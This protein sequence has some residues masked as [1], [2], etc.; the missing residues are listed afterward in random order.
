MVHL[1]SPTCCP[2]MRPAFGSSFLA[3]LFA[4]AGQLSA[5]DFEAMLV[6]PL[7]IHAGGQSAATVTA[8]YGASREPADLP[9]TLH[10]SQGGVRTSALGTARTGSSG[11]VVIPFEVPANGGGVYKIEAEI[12]GISETLQAETTLS[13]APAILIET[14]KPIYKP[15]QTI[16]GRVVLLDNV[17]RPRGGEVELTFH[18][19]KGIRIDRKNLTA[20]EYGVAPF[21]LRLASEVNFGIWKIHASVGGSE[22][23]RDVRV[24]NYVLPRYELSAE[25]ERS[26]VLVDEPI[27]GTVLARYFFGKPVDGTVEIVAKRYVGDWEIFDTAEGTLTDGSMD[28]QLDPVGFVA[29][30]PGASGLGTITLE[31]AATDSTGYSQSVTEILTVSE[32]PVVLGLISKTKTLKPKIPADVLVTAKAPDSKPLEETVKVD[33]VF[34]NPYGDE[35]GTETREIT[36]TNGGGVISVMPPDETGRAKFEATAVAG[37]RTARASL[38][39]NAAYSPSSSFLSVARIGGDS[40]VA[41]GEEVVFTATSTHSGTVFYDIY[42]GGRTVFSGASETREVRFFTTPDMA[43][44]AKLVAYIINPDNEVSADTVPFNVS[45]PAAISIATEVSQEDLRPGDEVT[46]TINAGQKA[47]VGLS[48]VDLSVLALGKSR[49][50]L[51]EVFAELERR[52]MEPQVETHEAPEPDLGPPRFWGDFRS[53]GALDILKEAGL[54]LV[55][56]EGVFVPV[57]ND[58]WDMFLDAAGPPEAGN[59]DRDKSGEEENGGGDAIRVRQFFPETWVWNPV[60]LTDDQGVATLNLTVPD[61][62]TGWQLSAMGTS[63]EGLGFGERQIIVFQEFFVEPDIPVAVT[64]GEEF[65]VRI[66]IYNYLEVPQTVELSFGDGDWFDLLGEAS[67]TVEVPRG[68]ATS[69]SFPIRPTLVG[70]HRV[71]VTARGSVLSDAVIRTIRVEPEGEPVEEVRN[72]VIKAGETADLDTSLPLYAVPDSGKAFLHVTPSPVAQT[73]SGVEGLLNMPFGCGEQ[74]MIFL[75]PDVEVLRYLK[76]IDQLMPEVQAEAEYL[77]NVGYQRELTFQSDDGGFA[78]FGGKDGSLWLTAFVL[79]TFSGAREVRDIDEAV[80]AQAANMLIGRQKPDGSFQTDDFLIHKEMD[81]GLSNIYAMAAYVANALAD[82]GDGAVQEALGKAA[83]YLAAQR[84]TVNDD[85]YSLSIAAV[86]LGK[87]PG[88]EGASGEVTDRLLE[89]AIQ[90]GAGLHWE[91]YPIETTGYA[92]MALLAQDRPQAAAAVE[93]LSTQRNSLGGY[94]QSTQD[95]VVAIRA[96]IAAAMKVIGELDITL[97]V[98]DGESTLAVLQVDGSNYDLLQSVELPVGRAS[99][100]LLRS[101]SNDGKDGNV[102]YQVAL[103]YHVPGDRLPPPND[104]SIEVIYDAEGIEVDQIVD[105]IVRVAYTGFKE[106]TGMTIVDV[107]I[108]TGFKAVRSSLDALVTAEIASRVDVAGR[109]VIIYIDGLTRGTPLEFKIKVIATY[110]VKA[111][112][113]VSRTYEYYDPDVQATTRGPALTVSPLEVQPGSFIRGDANADGVID[114]SD[115]IAMLGHFFVGDFSIQCIDRADVN[116]DGETNLT[117][118]IDLLNFLFLGGEPPEAPFPQPGLDET[119]DNLENRDC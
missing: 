77:I 72:S 73:L 62:I 19:G 68:S 104:M 118:V 50:H 55:A 4:F 90:D 79:S 12:G 100:L 53:P 30:T 117:D 34:F 32:T 91:P 119:L 82:Y 27:Q 64:R 5:G 40:A 49:L 1:P 69:A 74:N 109:K 48:I 93:W 81:G 58:M 26:W 61:S 65:P 97:T 78:A 15:S 114:I 31:I 33:I 35:I 18:D 43:P 98:L 94:G 111:E 92:A 7:E 88:F 66:Q 107:G 116:D 105:V 115:A 46:L 113:M 9:V 51:G 36:T 14:D 63:P 54:T 41:V 89:L 25:F 45:L 76:V 6:A 96:L 67:L 10:L 28:F 56:T 23:S 17:L 39:L 57:G 11:H 16:Q 87:I 13:D 20:N 38:E 22:S 83:G 102:G 110:P 47:M 101:E 37:E 95:T 21:E 86:A 29:G 103:K 3:V 42:A 8:F 60:L 2:S 59:G 52:F 106:E 112:S 80:L 108:P 99:G 24:E 71:Q 70:E 84:T 44:K 85:A 75:A